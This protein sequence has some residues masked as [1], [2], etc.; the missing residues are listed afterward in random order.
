MRE[1]AFVWGVRCLGVGLR[2]ESPEKVVM[3]SRRGPVERV[4]ASR[5]LPVSGCMCLGRSE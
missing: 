5:M 2:Q 3:C 1:M 4:F